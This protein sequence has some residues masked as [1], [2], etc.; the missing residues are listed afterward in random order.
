MKYM[1]FAATISALALFVGYLAQAGFPTIV[2]IATPP[3]Q[4][5]HRSLPECGPGLGVADQST[6]VPDVRAWERKQTV[7]SRGTWFLDP[8]PM[9][10]KGGY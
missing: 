6:L 8:T 1:F 7:G 2:A 10:G 4:S 9:M 3:E 5:A